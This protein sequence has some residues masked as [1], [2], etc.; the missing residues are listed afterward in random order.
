MAERMRGLPPVY[1][2]IGP[3]YARH[4]CADPR[5][6]ESIAK[7]M[8]LAPPGILADIGAGTGNYSRAI[9]DLGFHIRAVEP[10][11]AMRR[12]AISHD[13]VDWHRGAAESIPLP[14]HSVDGVFCILA[15]H[16]FSSLASAVAEMA[17]I[18]STGP[19]VMLTFDPRMAENPWIA[20]YF[21]EIW[22]SAFKVAPPLEEVCRLF[23]THARRR[24]T[25]T[26]WPV[27][28]D[29]LD[30]FMAAGW[31]TPELYLDPEVRAGISAFALAGQA[32]LDDGLERLKNDIE[33]GTWNERYRH[34]LDL[35]TIDWG[36]RFLKAV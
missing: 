28:C 5:I 15:S 20:D 14:D 33:T 7:T 6:V 17:R 32:A 25:I 9:A 34:L 3:G 36:Y 22:E 35:D 1:D 27:P 11:E 23:D 4:R 16:H 29:L 30:R 21:P 24:V 13:A 10:S 8:G 26:P 31:R 12:Q 19:L 18:C 2:Q